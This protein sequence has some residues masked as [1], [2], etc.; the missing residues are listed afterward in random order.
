MYTLARNADFRRDA[1]L[2]QELPCHRLKEMRLGTKAIE[3]VMGVP[4]DV[5]R[6]RVCLVVAH[7]SAHGAAQRVIG[8]EVLQ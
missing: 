5:G 6:I 1:S 8:E 4:E 7:S 3:F 2:A